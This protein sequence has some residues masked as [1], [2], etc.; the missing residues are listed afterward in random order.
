MSPER[1]DLDDP[2]DGDGQDLPYRRTAITLAH[3]MTIAVSGLVALIALGS[4]ALGDGPRG[5]RPLGLAL[6]LV[7]AVTVGVTWSSLRS[8]RETDRPRLLWMASVGVAWMAVA[9]AAPTV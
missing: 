8:F 6:F 1:V 3:G 7:S 2:D 5:S 9:L 4:V